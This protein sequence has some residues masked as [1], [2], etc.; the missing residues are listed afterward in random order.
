MKFLVI[1]L[2]SMGKRRIRNLQSLNAGEIVGFDLRVDRRKES[3]E[4]FGIQTIEDIHQ[5]DLKYF[6]AWIIS[7]PPVIHN[8]YI[9]LAIEHRKPAFVEASVI[10]AGLEELQQFAQSNNIL[11]ASSC[12]LRF[13][14]AI[15][16]IKRIV[17]DKTYG[18]VTSF[19]YHIGQYLP[20]WHPWEDVKDFYVGE[21]KTGG[22]REMVPFELTWIVDILGFPK[23]V[24]CLYGK[25]MN[26]GADINDTY[27]IAMDFG[28]VLGS[29]TVDVVS[30]YGTRNLLLNMER[31]QLLW[32][33][34]EQE[35]KVYDAESQ[36][37]IS[38]SYTQGDAAAGYN[39]NI[40]EDMYIEEMQAFLNALQ[41]KKVF[42]NLLKEDIKV[43]QLLHTIEEN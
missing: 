41:G 6:D 26:V 22:A 14:P 8:Q 35:I 34:D 37:W 20:D 11:I 30:R 17:K 19:S 38:H 7:T 21:K 12:T 25:T 1:G 3:E 42:P 18:N 29:M 10:L 5:A 39:K 23:E 33:W 32:R 28:G 27:A 36:K 40:A 2:G 24:R 4:K 31:G 15:K 16:E 13:H 43:L 9:K